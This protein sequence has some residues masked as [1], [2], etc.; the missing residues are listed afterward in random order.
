MIEK[1]KRHLRA[2]AHKL[3]P[4]V[5]TGSAGMTDGVL[6]EVEIA[7]AHHELIKVRINAMDK[8]SREKMIKTIT[9]TCKCELVQSIGHIAVFYRAAKNP[10]IQ[11]PS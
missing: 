9:N 4:V 6:N 10:V 3:K 11:L 7:I 1:Q 8:E 5:L 2:L